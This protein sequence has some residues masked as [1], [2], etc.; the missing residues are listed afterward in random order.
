MDVS[1]FS[2]VRELTKDVIASIAASAAC[3]YTGQPFDTVKVRMQV[4]PSEF[5]GTIQCF[6]RTISHEAVSSLWRGSVPAFLGALSE[7]A[8]AFGINGFLKRV[9]STDSSYNSDKLNITTPLLTGAITGAATAT[10]LC[11]CDVVKCRAQTSAASST[12]AIVSQIVAQRG[13][14]GLFTGYSAQMLR[15][16]PFG[17]AFFGSYEIMVQLAKRHTKFS[18]ST[19]YFMSGGFAGQIAWMSTIG[20]DSIKSAIQTAE[21]PLTLQATA[22]DILKSRGWRGFIVGVEVTVLRAFPANAALFL[23]YEHTRKM[24]S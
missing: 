8:I 12:S 21:K 19:I 18:D 3:T 15:D 24:L 4:N 1:N 11:P 2:A 22:Q 6:N 7:N 23:A 9:L 14:R 13:Y 5:S 10:V 16:I 20:F 17:A